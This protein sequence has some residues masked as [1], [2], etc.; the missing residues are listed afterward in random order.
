[1]K[2][3]V[4]FSGGKDSCYAAF[5]ASKNHEISCLISVF[6]KNSESYMFHTA[7]IELTKKQSEAMEIPIIIGETKGE[8]EK[9]LEDL[10]KIIKKAQEKYNIE[11]I[12]TGA[13]NSNYQKSRI[14]K[15]CRKLD[16]SCINPL[17]NINHLEYLKKLIENNF[18]IIVI[19]IAAYPLKEDFLG[20]E[21]NQKFLERLKELNKEYEIS[22]VGEGG[23]FE[24]LVLD[25]PLF[26][27]KIKI[28]DF[29][30]EYSD[31]VGVLK[32]KK[33]KLIEK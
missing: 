30:K 20:L 10:E 3:G 9:E 15:I 23:E 32:I 1:M 25:C 26:K 18:E 5:E 14:E 31:Y 12:V 24:T 28:I 6:S 4:L 29:E 11:G 19:G 7:N 16:L 21:I 13:V 22:F 33:I 8:K 17:W 2:V 27:K